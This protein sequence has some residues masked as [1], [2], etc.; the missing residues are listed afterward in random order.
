MVYL[1]GSAGPDFSGFWHDVV[2]RDDR[3]TVVPPR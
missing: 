3:A 2:A 1:S